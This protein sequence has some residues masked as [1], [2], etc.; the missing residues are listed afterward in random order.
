VFYRG[1]GAY[2]VGRLHRGGATIP[3]ALA[4]LNPPDG[5]TIDAVLLSEDDLSILFSFAR[6][7]FH[8]DVDHPHQLVQFL[9]TILPRKP[10]AELYIALGFNK[11]GKTEFYRDFLRHLHA[12]H[13]QFEIA[14]GEK[15]M[16][17]TVFTLPSYDVVFKI[18]KDTFAYPKTATRG[19]VI[20]KYQLVFKHDRVGRLIDAQ[21]FEH[22]TFDRARF[23][24]ELLDELRRTAANSVT[25]TETTVSIRHVY[26]ERR[27][28]PL[29]L[30]VQE[31]D[32]A[33]TRAA[34]IDYGQCVKDLI[35]SNIFPGDILLKNFGVTR[36]GR[37]I[38]YDY[39]ELGLLTDY[40][41][42]TMPA[43]RD[44]EED[45][46]A[47]P[48]FFVGERDVFPEE[49]KTFL[50]LRGELRALFTQ[51]HGDLFGVKL[52][53]TMQQRHRNGDIV[54]IFPYG[55]HQRLRNNR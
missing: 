14:P 9:H 28:T 6:S 31:R 25:I 38:F 37:V 33:A 10:I 19:E 5:V 16:V 55:E 24:A 54:D 52:W 13:D 23:S 36:H 41:F 8:V 17:M 30:Y 35:A 2:I 44:D 3:L 43:A 51:H 53:Q 12:S 42:R 26:I 39:D 15:G 29:N 34:I 27:I 50:G 4:L 32:E 46:A 21:E 20:A 11:H 22:L 40:H 49:F 1:K 7:Y 18:I 48:W 47:E 45:Y